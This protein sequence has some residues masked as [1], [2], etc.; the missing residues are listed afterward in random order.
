[1]L[2]VR[3]PLPGSPLVDLPRLVL[4]VD[5]PDGEEEFVDSVAELSRKAEEWGFE[6]VPAPSVGERNAGLARNLPHVHR[7]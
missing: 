6:L 7:V 1:M 2:V 4:N 3:L 5:L